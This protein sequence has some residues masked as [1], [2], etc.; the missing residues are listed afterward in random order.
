[1]LIYIFTFNTHSFSSVVI[2]LILYASNIGCLESGCLHVG[3]GG[4]YYRG[5]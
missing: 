3:G 4:A 5:H 2:M 1:M